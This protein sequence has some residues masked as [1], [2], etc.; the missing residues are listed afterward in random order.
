[1]ARTSDECF[2][3]YLNQ[4]VV[5]KEISSSE[6]I[7]H[8]IDLQ[9]QIDGLKFVSFSSFQRERGMARTKQTKKPVVQGKKMAVK[10]DIR[11]DKSSDDESS[12]CDDNYGTEEC[13]FNMVECSNPKCGRHGDLFFF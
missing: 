9:E 13:A 3:A 8:C 6:W 1:M 11:K 7:S 4:N 2:V 10:E 5:A 12:S